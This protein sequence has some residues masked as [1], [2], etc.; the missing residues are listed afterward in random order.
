I[1]SLALS[2]VTLAGCDTLQ[3][4]TQ[5]GARPDT[6]LPYRTRL[7]READR[8]DIVIAVDNRG[9]GL[10]EV[11][12]S[13]RFEATRHCLATVGSSQ[14]E[15]QTDAATGDW[16]YTADGARLVFRARCIGGV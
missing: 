1:L 3:A 12:E 13:V 11:R 6:P 9:A 8:R 14:T 10:D 16:A 4:V 15:W 5:R 7:T 2:P